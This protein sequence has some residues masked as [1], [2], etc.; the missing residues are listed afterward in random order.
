MT[1][2]AWGLQLPN[3]VHASEGLWR[4]QYDYHDTDFS[5][6]QFKSQDQARGHLFPVS[7]HDNSDC[8]TLQLKCTRKQ[9]FLIKPIVSKFV[10]DE[11]V[12][13]GS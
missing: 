8:N 4:L 5:Y 3:S 9:T 13:Q 1:E 11:A 2:Q 12:T 6:F 7:T 10:Q